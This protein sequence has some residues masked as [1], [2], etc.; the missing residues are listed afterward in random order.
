MALGFLWAFVWAV[1][2]GQF[3]DDFAPSVRILFDDDVE[4]P[5]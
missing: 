5:K 2:S 3:E 4:L 1:K